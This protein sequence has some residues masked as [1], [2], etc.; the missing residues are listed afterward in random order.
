[1][2]SVRLAYIS[3]ETQV[4][5]LQGHDKSPAS[6]LSAWPHCAG[7]LT[8]GNPKD[9]VTPQCGITQVRLASYLE[10]RLLGLTMTVRSHPDMVKLKYG[11]TYTPLSGETQVW[12]P[13]DPFG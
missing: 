5:N 7:R 13:S 3:G 11:I 8:Y 10:I 4:W 12:N 6:G 2:E 9:L 1:M